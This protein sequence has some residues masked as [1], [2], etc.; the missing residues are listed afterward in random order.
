MKAQLLILT[1]L[2]F[3]LVTAVFA[4][5]NVEPV[6]VDFLFARLE[7]PL[8]LVILV[9]ALLGALSAGLFGIVRTYRLQRRVRQLERQLAAGRN[10]E[11]TLTEDALRRIKDEP[12]EE[13]DDER[14]EPQGGRPYLH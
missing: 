11:I 5:F 8:I 1:A 10:V 12:N 9:S 3:A 4:V 6:L 14:D 13:E 2:L 7:T